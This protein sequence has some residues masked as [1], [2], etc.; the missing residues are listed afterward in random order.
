M[1]RMVHG[2]TTH[3]TPQEE[4]QD[5]RPPPER[6]LDWGLRTRATHRQLPQ[7]SA[8]WWAGLAGNTP[9]HECRLLRGTALTTRWR[10]AAALPLRPYS[11]RSKS[12]EAVA[13]AAGQA[14]TVEP[15]E[16]EETLQK[17]EGYATERVNEAKGEVARFVSLYKEYI[18]APDVTKK[19]IYLETM[20][21]IMPRLGNVIIT[22][23]KGNNVLPLLQMQMNKK[24]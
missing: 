14:P 19:R 16:A 8:M 1:W 23:E 21:D 7:A 11:P 6:Y 24:D 3:N 13:R 18:K 10:T 20:A 2:R 17:S 4:D 9:Q 5:S 15:G 12:L 22:D